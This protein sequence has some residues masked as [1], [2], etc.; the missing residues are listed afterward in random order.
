M[1]EQCVQKPTTEGPRVPSYT[2]GPS[3][4]IV[5]IALTVLMVTLLLRLIFLPETSNFTESKSDMMRLIR[6]ITWAA[7]FFIAFLLAVRS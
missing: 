5:M 4:L 1:Q 2:E 3:M 6:I 7:A